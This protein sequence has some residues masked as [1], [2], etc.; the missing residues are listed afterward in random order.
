MGGNHQ[1]VNVWVAGRLKTE[2][3]QKL[4]N[5]KKFREIIKIDD[6]ST[7]GYLKT[8]IDNVLEKFQKLAVIHS[9]EKFNLLHFVNLFTAFVQGCLR[10]HIF[11]FNTVQTPWNLYFL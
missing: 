11:I 8:N 1:K 10:K 6:A 4:E 7:I 9:I 5:F 2:D 3:L